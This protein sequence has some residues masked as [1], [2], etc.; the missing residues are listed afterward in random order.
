MQITFHGAAGTVTGSKHV[1]TLE[2]N[3]KLLLD[4]G[5]FQ[6]FGKDTYALNKD[7]GFKASEI[8]MLFLSHTHI[9]H[10]GLIPALVKQG[11]NGKIYCT[12]ATFDLCKIMLADSA[13][14][15][16]ADARH[17]NK[18]LK[19]Q[20]KPLIT[21]LY[22]IDDV[23]KA[24]TLFETVKYDVELKISDFIKVTF[25]D[26]G[27]ILG[28]ATVNLKILEGSQTKTIAFT[29]DIGRYNQPLLQNPHSFPPADVIICE[30][31]YGNRL[32][33]DMEK[34]EGY[35]LNAV[36]KTCKEKRGKLIIP[37]FS[38][39]RTQE[40]VY[41]LNKLD[42]HGLLPDVK[43]FIDS[44]LS[45]NATNVMRDYVG[46]LN[47]SVQRFV[48]ERE[49]PF[50][51]EDVV[52]ISSREESQQL[53]EIKEPCIIISASGMAEAGRIK[54]HL[55]HN[56]S[57]SKNTIM[58]VGYAEKESLSGKLRNGEKVV[59]IFGDEYD[60]N[61]DVIVVESFSAHAD[62]KGI[63]QFLS[64]QDP[65]TVQ[66]IFLVHG[67]EE[68][69]NHLKEELKNSNFSNIYIP[70]KHESFYI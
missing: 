2:N 36:I 20:E 62:Y 5:M 26:N 67:E 48:Q 41:A 53:N 17:I 65:E 58:I 29:G 66:K 9:D 31:T 61:A 44:P 12:P 7:F 23:N 15:Q 54:H 11:F 25:T 55:M 3:Q 32:H 40:V 34:T 21:P 59:R 64:C 33:D 10:S 45:L 70:K 60:V 24:L 22:T 8:D 42:L 37:A 63:I 13:Y 39:G 43:I 19:K 68:A 56:I 49:D 38:L 1:I 4:C 28:S 35:I 69:Q 47:K 52:Y 18:K 6:G 27:H 46:N 50:G 14:I 16:E 51:F 30:S 57:D